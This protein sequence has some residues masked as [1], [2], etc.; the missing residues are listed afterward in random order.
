MAMVMVGTTRGK[1]IR[2]IVAAG[3]F[4]RDWYSNIDE[5]LIIRS[6]IGPDPIVW[7]SGLPSR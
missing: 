5:M 7:T 2:V 6:Q 3:R 1:W 4:N